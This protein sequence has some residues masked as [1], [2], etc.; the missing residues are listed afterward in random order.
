MFSPGDGRNRGSKSIA[1][2]REG[3]NWTSSWGDI[4]L[5]SPASDAQLNGLPDL[6][7]QNLGRGPAGE[8][9]ERGNTK[10]RGWLYPELI[11]SRI[12]ALLGSS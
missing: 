6:N 3:L 2:A 4:L 12:C 9:C 1:S 10:W 11:S 7:V 8:N 5:V